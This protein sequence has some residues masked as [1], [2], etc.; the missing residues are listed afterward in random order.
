[1]RALPGTAPPGR[2]KHASEDAVA[3]S[4][5]LWLSSSDQSSNALALAACSPDVVRTSSQSKVGP[6]KVS[7]GSSTAI[8]E[9]RMF[10][11]FG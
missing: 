6:I 7:R 11:R 3:A 10:S 1:V 9:T 5:Y 4:R 2:S 8:F